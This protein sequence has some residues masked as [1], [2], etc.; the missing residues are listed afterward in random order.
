MIHHRLECG[1]AVGKTEEHD[2]GFEQSFIGDERCFPFITFLDPDVVISPS[3]VELGKI[4][5]AFQL[6]NQLRD[7]WKGIGVFNCH[8][9]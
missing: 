4:A 2:K 8:S 7:K 1:W 9:I 6:I 5:S 3:Y